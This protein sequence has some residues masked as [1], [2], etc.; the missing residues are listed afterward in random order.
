M[1]VTS[2]AKKVWVALAG[3]GLCGFVVAH[4]A[5]NL[6]IFGPPDHYNQYADFLHHSVFLVPSEIGLA[7]LFVLHL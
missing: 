2:V 5:G 3:L 1:V 6:V 7:V 4:L